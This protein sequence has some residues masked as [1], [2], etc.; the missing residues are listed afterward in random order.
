MAHAAQ[1]EFIRRISAVFPAHFRRRRV[2]EIGSLN[3]NGSVRQFFQDCDYTGI[4]VARGPG[5]DVV[6]G[7]HVFEAP[8]FDVVISCE[9]MEHNPHWEDTM[10]N[11]VRLC[12]PDGLV[13]MTCA[14][15]GRPEHGTSISQPGDSP[16]TLSIGWDYY[17]NLTA[18][19]LLGAGVLA[20][21]ACHR[22]FVNWA[23]HDLYMVALR[24]PPTEDEA[25]GLRQITAAY[26]RQNFGSLRGFRNM[27]R[28]AVSQV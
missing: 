8:P 14:T 26:R 28:V 27:L 22:F 23:S 24:R 16:L 12:R 19:D 20:G 15:T 10:R 21:L 13:L 6:C 2:L 11:M 18:S 9:A 17:R 7:G 1:F 4:D 5:V 3:I 25:E